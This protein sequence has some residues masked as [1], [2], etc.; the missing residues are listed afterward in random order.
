LTSQTDLHTALNNL[1]LSINGTAV[2]SPNFNSTSP[3]HLANSAAVNFNSNESNVSASVGPA[4]DT[5]YGVVECGSGLSCDNGLMSVSGAGGASVTYPASATTNIF[6]TDSKWIVS[7]QCAYGGSTAGSISSYVLNGFEPANFNY[8]ATPSLAAGTWLYLYGFTGNSAA[9]NGQVVQVESSGLTSSQFTAS[10]SNPSSSTGSETGYFECA[11]SWPRQAA[12]LPYFAS[13]GSVVNVSVSGASSATLASDYTTNVHPYTTAVTGNPSVLYWMPSSNDYGASCPSLP[14]L[15][16]YAQTIWN[17]AHTDG[18]KVV[19]FTLPLGTVNGIGCNNYNAASVVAQFN[20]WLKAQVKNPSSASVGYVDA[21]VDAAAIFTSSSDPNMY[22]QTGE[23]GH[24]TDGGNSVGAQ[25]T[26]STL[27]LQGSVIQASLNGQ[28]YLLDNDW[29]LGSTSCWIDPNLD[30]NYFC[31]QSSN[32]AQGEE[33][34]GLPSNGNNL[35]DFFAT[36]NGSGPANYYR[37]IRSGGGIGWQN[38]NGETDGAETSISSPGQKQMCV[39]NGNPGDCS[40]TWQS[41]YYFSTLTTA[42]TAGSAC[43]PSGVWAFTQDGHAS[44]CLASIWVLKI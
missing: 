33:F 28:Q 7:G 31:I 3:L 22:N 14:T 32:N 17:D 24:F 25:L 23:T 9:L 10:I 15:E 20:Q 29:H 39:G 8:S 1:V 6:Y 27:S 18:A 5:S 37:I 34:G 4:S 43:S 11:G 44:V 41:N 38:T 30:S 12:N 26:N 19:A 40:G 36:N 2:P 16:G 42:P 13:H 21:V 35:I